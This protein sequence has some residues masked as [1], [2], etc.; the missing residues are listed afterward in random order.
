MYRVL[1]VEDE[2]I[3]LETL[4]DYIDWKKNGISRV[5]T[6]RNGRRALECL[7][8][9][10]ADI[11]ITDI[12][13][14]GMSGIELAETIVRRGYPCKIVFL[15]GYD[16][17]SYIHSAFQ[18]NAVDYLLK[19]F[20]IEEVEAC[21]KKVRSE[22]EKSEIAD[23]SR[24][25]AAKQLLEMA[26]RE[27]QE[28][29]LLRKN[30]R[31]VFGEELEEC[32]FGI[33]AVYGKTEENICSKIQEKYK[34]I[35]YISKT[36]RISILLLAGYLSVK[37]TA[38]QIW[39]DLKEDAPR[40]VG[41]C[42][43]AW[44]ADCLY[45]KAEKLR[46]CCVLAFHM[47]PPE[48]FC[49]DEKE[50]E[51][52]KAYHFRE[53]KERREEICR[54]VSNGKKQ[55][56]LQTMKDYFQQLKGLAPK[57][58]AGEVYNLYM[59]LW[60][61]LVLSD[62][63][64]ENWMEAEKI[65]RE[66]EIFEANNSYQMREKMKQYL[67]RMLAF[68]EEQ[69]QNPNY[70]AVYQV[71]T[72]LQEHCSESADIE[73]LAAEVGLSPNYLRSLF[74]EATGKTRNVL[75]TEAYQSAEQEAERIEKNFS[76]M[77][78]PYETILDVLYVDQMLSG[79]LFQDYSNDSY[80]DMFYYIDKKLSEICLMNA[81]IYKICFYSNNET[82]P[83]DN[84]YFYSMQDLDRRECVLTF[85]AIGETVFCGTSGDGKAFHMNRLMNFYPQG[86]MKS[87]LSLQIENQQIQPLLETI[88]S[89]DEIY[90]VDQKGYILAASE[91]EMAGLPIRTRMP[92]E[93]LE[94]KAQIEFE[95]DGIS[96]IGNIQSGVF[97]TKIL[98]IS[99]KETVLK[100]A[101]AVS[102]RMMFLILCSAAMVFL[103]II[104]YT[105]WISARVQKVVYAAKRMGQGEFDYRLENMGEDEIGQI[106]LAFNQLSDQIQELIRENYEKK[107]RIQ[108]SELN[109]LQEQINPHFL[110]N[111]LAVISALAMREGG[112]QTMQAV[113]NLSSFYRISLNKGKQVL[114]IQEEVELLQSYL[115]IQQ[116]RF[117]DSVQVEYEI[118]RE[119]LTYR[120]IKLLLQPLVENAIHHARKEEEVLHIAVR[121]QKEERDVVFQVTDDGCGI[122][123]E[124]LIKLRS[125]L[126][127][128][129]EGY[130]LRNVANRVRLAYGEDYGVRIESQEGYGTTVS[131]RIPVNE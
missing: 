64:L 78:E 66:N 14:P 118:A 75:L 45:E 48:L 121:I 82:L 84:Y 31:G 127:R 49:A 128:S 112:K 59:Y 99:D 39:N 8:E 18:V 7:E 107:I 97:G 124:K 58:F 16:D 91:P 55:E 10:M 123:A 74:K 115:K 89:T 105:R 102:R 94:Q 129:E 117:R 51:E 72:Y 43:G 17:F 61:R 90:L 88:N 92:E 62:E 119:V 26:L 1:L 101:K 85:D 108:T 21:L 113:K 83:Q 77:V 110:Y 33:I 57:T 50:T 69:N 15:T 116:M 6:A 53:Q 3:E 125:S 36:E 56:T 40:A 93:D 34:G 67:E 70:Y 79:Y 41:W 130:G 86:G 35:R 23:W 47:D 27:K 2:E 52:E 68:F 13:M 44:T 96:K 122:E 30:F 37:D 29:E 24:K 100:D 11:V 80:E 54:L 20:T 104:C 111:A 114:S 71:K 109:L 4:R 98:V 28:T 46:N 76:T 63:L 25:T 126:R 32:R 131:V 81:G 12:Q 60:N 19:P 38:F 106:G 120:T 95:R 73:K 65:L 22:L 9:N 87:V 103:C 5:F 42:S